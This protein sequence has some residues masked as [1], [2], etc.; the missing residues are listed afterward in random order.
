MSEAYKNDRG[1]LRLLP[2]ANGGWTIYREGNFG[3]DPCIGAY[4]TTDQMLTEL[5]EYLKYQP[6]PEKE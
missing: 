6:T 1:G 3:P 2:H 5:V 4:R